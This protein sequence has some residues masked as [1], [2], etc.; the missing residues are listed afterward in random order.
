MRW[1][2]ASMM[3][4]A[5]ALAAGCTSGMQ[6]HPSSDPLQ[7]EQCVST[8]GPTE[9]VG[10]AV[11]AAAAWGVEGCRVNGCNPPY[12]CNDET[13]MCERL[14]CG[15]GEPCPAPFECDTIEGHCE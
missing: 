8:G 1:V 12:T 5:T 4:A 14:A 15:E 2:S 3:V 13:R 6:C 10:T 7:R 9:A 11:V